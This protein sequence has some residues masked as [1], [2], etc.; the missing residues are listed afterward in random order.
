MGEKIMVD[1]RFCGPPDSANG[2]YI[3]GLVAGFIEG[4]AGITLRKPPPLGRELDVECTNDRSVILRDGDV[5]LAEGQPASLDLDVPSPPT[6]AEAVEASKLSPAHNKTAF[7][8]CFVCGCERAECDG[9]RIFAGPVT[10]N[11]IV[12]APWVPD[13][14]LS[15][16]GGIVKREFLWAA[17]DCPGGYAFFTQGFKIM[18]LGRLVANVT[19][20]VKAGEKCTVIGWRISEE[21]RKSYA[22]SALFS[23]SGELCAVGRSTW[24]ELKFDGA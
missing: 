9:L 6:Y 22:G 12:A 3:C 16:D 24:I 18:L 2:G 17:L 13:I 4:T 10:G 8:Y 7:S 11:E 1:Q 5:V 19:G 21:G 20:H 15:D 23:E 14:S